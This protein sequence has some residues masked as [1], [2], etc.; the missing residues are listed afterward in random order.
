[1]KNYYYR[2][3]KDTR[4]DNDKTQAEIANILGTTQQQYGKYENGVREIPTHHLKTLCIYYNL[5][6]DYLLGLT[7]EQRP[8]K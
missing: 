7:D 1:M 2:R 6:A 5:S 3:L 4:E 8:L